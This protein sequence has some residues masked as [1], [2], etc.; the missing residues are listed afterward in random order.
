MDPR[1][2]VW[3]HAKKMFVAGLV[4]GSAGN[5]SRRV[6]G[7][8]I[9]IT[10]TSIAYDALTIEQIVLIEVESGRAVDSIRG[11]SYELPMHLAIYRARPDVHAIVHTHAPF[12]TTL[13]L[14][15]RPLPPVIDEAVV[16]LGGTIEV[17]DYAFTGTDA[18]G[19][20]V[21]RTLGDRAAVLLANHGNVCIG[22]DL[23]H[24]LHAAIVMEAAARAYVQALQIGDPVS[25]P[26]D[27]IAAGHRLYEARRRD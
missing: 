16:H 25:L 27:A 2:D 20:N 17:S 5:L 1:E 8:R 24:A 15:R 21:V 4:T 19:T 12:V 10:P 3:Q 23:E 9:A 26:N 11:P 14:L 22:R 18:V 13:S 6:D 7:G